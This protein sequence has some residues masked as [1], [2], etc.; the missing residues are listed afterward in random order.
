MWLTKNEKAILK[1]L[2]DNGKLSDTDMAKDLGISSQVVGRIRK[3]LEE[4][5]ITKYSIEL[6]K[7]AL[8]VNIF[9]RIKLK[10]ENLTAKDTE[11][12]EQKMKEDPNV[13]FI[14][15][16]LSGEGEYILTAGFQDMN[17]LRI[18][19]ENY[20]KSSKKNYTILE[21]NLLPSESLLK[22]S[23]SDLCN[24]MIDLCGTKHVDVP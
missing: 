15:K 23:C 7:K 20:K 2:L 24:K 6:D 1:L 16:T 11:E 9:A 10:F 13:M 22:S 17:E 8:G 12:V 3:K 19:T 14:F 5:I 4:D 21:M 18:I